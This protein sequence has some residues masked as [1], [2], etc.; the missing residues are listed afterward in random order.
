VTAAD[1]DAPSAEGRRRSTV[2]APGRS[3]A[4]EA[5]G[6]QRSRPSRR[7]RPRSP[8]TGCRLRLR[9]SPAEG[10]AEPW[11]DRPFLQTVPTSAPSTTRAASWPLPRP[12][13]TEKQ[14]LVLRHPRGLRAA[15]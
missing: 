12:H 9:E 11:R 4:R 8:P 2:T 3:P 13:Q 15:G 6:L 5:P 7:R 10:T 14:T 1:A